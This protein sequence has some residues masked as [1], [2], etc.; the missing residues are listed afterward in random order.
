MYQLDISAA[1][2]SLN[3]TMYISSI[4]DFCNSLLISDSDLY[5][6]SHLTFNGGGG[7]A[8]SQFP[9]LMLYNLAIPHGYPHT[10]ITYIL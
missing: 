9:S 5:L 1:Q 7:G 6:E 3:V 2:V 10:K 8:D 4:D